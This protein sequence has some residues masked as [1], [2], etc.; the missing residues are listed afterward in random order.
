MTSDFLFYPLFREEL[1]RYLKRNPENRGAGSLLRLE[2]EVAFGRPLLEGI[3]ASGVPEKFFFSAKD[4]PFVL[5]G[6]GSAQVV[7]AAR[8]EDV[9]ERFRGF[10]AADPTIPVFGGFSFDA[11]E[12]SAPEWE[13]FGRFRFTL[14]V[15]ELRISEGGARVAVNHVRKKG[16]STGEALG[17]IS[18]ILRELDAARRPVSGAA[19]LPCRLAKELVPKKPRWNRM[20]QK[21]LETIR[22]GD[23]QKIVLARKMIITRPEP[24]DPAAIIAALARIEE[25]SFTFY[26]QIADG[27]AFLGRSPERLFRMHDGRIMAEAIAGTRPRGETPSDDR[28]LERELLHSRKELEEHRFVAGFVETGMKRICDDVQIAAAEE[29]LKLRNVQHVVTRFTGRSTGERSPLAIARIFHPTPAVG[30][31]PPDGILEYLRRNEPFRRGWYGAPIGWMNRM[32]ADFVVG[33]RSALV[34]GNELHI[35]AGA[36]IVG[37]SNAR[38]EWEETEKK[39]DNFAAILGECPC[40]PGS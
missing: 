15:I 33:I 10:W 4:S 11:A 27:I 8:P 23:L 2:R 18:A 24:W 9:L 32:D 5:G 19:D 17:E 40:P 25:D 22:A 6:L 34:R 16:Q 37:Q 30:G 20:I 28:R 12:E 13:P 26:Y 3:V 14:P 29:I 31:H 21:A 38:D 39:M 7:A 35:F 1:E 36:G